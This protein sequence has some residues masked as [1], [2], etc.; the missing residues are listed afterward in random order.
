MRALLGSAVNSLDRDTG[1]VVGLS[2]K[3][4]C[5]REGDVDNFTGYFRGSFA[6]GN[7]R[8]GADNSQNHNNC[9]YRNNFLF[10]FR[11]PRMIVRPKS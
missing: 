8:H 9:E 7:N 2:V 10:H 1:P 4:Y 11:P 5:D 3:G 6:L